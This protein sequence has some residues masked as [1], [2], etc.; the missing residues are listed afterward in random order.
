[1]PEF[2]ESLKRLYD[3][4]IVSLA[5]LEA[6]AEVG[7]ITAEELEYIL[8]GSG[9]NDLQTFYDAVTAEVGIV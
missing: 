2:I 9:D 4:G 5:K 3:D 7:K 1:M 8:S 6:M